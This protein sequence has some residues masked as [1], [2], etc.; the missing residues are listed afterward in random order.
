[1]SKPKLTKEAI[2]FIVETYDSQSENYTYSEIADL[3]QV[4]PAVN[5]VDLN[6]GDFNYAA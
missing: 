2:R 3:V 6:L 1:M 5:P 4:T